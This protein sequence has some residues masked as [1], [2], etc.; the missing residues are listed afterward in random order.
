MSN[1]YIDTNYF[2]NEKLIPYVVIPLVCLVFFLLHT[3]QSS[4]QTMASILLLFSPLCF[5]LSGYSIVEKNNGLKALFALIATYFI[6]N[7][8][9]LSQ[10]EF[11]K[12][13][14]ATY[15]ALFFW[16]LLPVS[17]ILLLSRNIKLHH[18][19]LIFVLAATFSAYPILNDYF[20]GYRRGASS[21][22]PIFWG[23]IA[24]CSSMIVFALRNNF[25]NKYLK[26]F[27]Y[28]A[29]VLG[30]TASFW[31]LTR[32][33]WISIPLSIVCLFLTKSINKKQLVILFT[34]ILAAVIFVP[35]I[36]S[37]LTTT[38]NN[39]NASSQGMT[40]G[41]DNSTQ[42]RLDMWNVSLNFI[43]Q[44]PIFGNGFSA[45]KNGTDK[46]LAEG[47]D[48]GLARNFDMPHNEFVHLL[49]SGGITSLILLLAILLALLN[50]FSNF[51]ENSAFKVAGYLLIIQFLVFSLS[52]I[53]FSTKLTIIYFC[54]ASAF[55]IY[56]GLSEKDGN[57]D[58]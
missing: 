6:Y 16:L 4:S 20:H 17:L 19:A 8:F 48:V 15:R 50:I 57:Y 23:N 25:T 44:N 9:I 47:K 28:I 13:S 14:L 46:M 58:E 42:A 18:I 40:V 38:F 30:L 1:K 24:L 31:S 12:L 56:A 53:F 26:V 22:H 41:L 7:F 33:G 2:V 36:N 11:D 37:R 49:V 21:G 45:Y 5:F 29:F 27:C 10:N 35:S 55:I 3:N 52:E 43:K 34:L 54:L 32:G 51:R 39:I